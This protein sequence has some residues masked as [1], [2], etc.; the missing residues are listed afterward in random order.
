MPKIVEE[1]LVE[2]EMK[3]GLLKD[4][5]ILG[6]V[7]KNNRK[8]SEAAMKKAVSLYEGKP[9]F[10]NHDIKNPS[11]SAEDRF[12]VLKNVRFHEG[13]LKGDLNYLT[14]HPMTARV[15]EDLNKKSGFFGLSHVADATCTKDGMVES[16]ESVYSVDLVTNPA[17]TINLMEAEI[18]EIEKIDKKSEPTTEDDRITKLEAKIEALTK[19]VNS[20][21]LA[22]Q[23]L[24]PNTS[25][26]TD[27]SIPTDPKLLAKWLKT[28]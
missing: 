18:T 5:V 22:P 13:K 23:S 15:G 3:D 11:R 7:S 24:A 26:S 19:A 17:T 2:A 28:A 10:M 25:E 9:V 14:T 12:G 1:I 21:Y 20:K 6:P 16:I 27:P 4:V 8:Y